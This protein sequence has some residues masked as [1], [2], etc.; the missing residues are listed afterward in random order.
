[1]KLKVTQT[2]DDKIRG[3]KI[4]IDSPDKESLQKYFGESF[5]I[6]SYFC[7]LPYIRISNSNY[8]ITLKEV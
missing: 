6:D 2:T 7:S 4:E 8:T 5:E 3:L 1:M